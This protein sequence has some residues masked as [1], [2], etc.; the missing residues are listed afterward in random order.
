[1][2]YIINILAFCTF[3]IFSVCCFSQQLPQFTQYMYNTISINPA[4]AGTQDAFIINILNRNQ[5][6]GIEGAPTT[7]TISLHTP[8]ARSKFAI[9]LSAIN[10]KL[11]FETT[12][13]T[14]IDVSYTLQL[15]EKYWLAFGLKVGGSKY[16]LSKD[17]LSDPVYGT[18]PFLNKTNHK[19]APNIGAGIYFRGESFYLGFS[20]PK[21]IDYERKTDIEYLPLERVS[22]YFNG[23]YIF[24]LHEY[25]K[26]KPSF[27]VKFTNGAPVSFTY[28]QI[29]F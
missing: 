20:A 15:Q 16:N 8:L 6:V 11:G 9:G 12:T 19:W 5:W 23:G 2:K 28:Q 7:Q 22:Y 29:S 13:Y 21:L 4:F 10:D 18:D 17:L 25:L 3:F 24:D 27:L 26:F 14:Y 1:M